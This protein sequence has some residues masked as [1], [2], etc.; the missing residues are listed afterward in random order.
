MPDLTQ[1]N[2][3]ASSASSSS[4]ADIQSTVCMFFGIAYRNGVPYTICAKRTTLEGFVEY[5][6]KWRIHR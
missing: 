3:D 5:L 1:L 2:G 4:M 6:T